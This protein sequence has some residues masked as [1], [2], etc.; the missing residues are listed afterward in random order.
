MHHPHR[1]RRH[2]ANSTH[3]PHAKNPK[4]KSAKKTY[5]R[6]ANRGIEPETKSQIFHSD[7]S[8]L[9]LLFLNIF[10]TFIV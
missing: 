6:G 3:P 10:K 2:R 9:G 1:P 5:E 7:R 8:L 4:A